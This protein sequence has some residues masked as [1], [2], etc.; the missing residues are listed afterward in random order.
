LIGEVSDVILD[1]ARPSS[2]YELKASG[3]KS[4]SCSKKKGKNPMKWAKVSPSAIV[5]R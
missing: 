2:L 4:G 5:S 3:R 1:E